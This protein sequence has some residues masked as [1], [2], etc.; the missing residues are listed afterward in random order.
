MGVLTRGGDVDYKRDLKDKW[1]TDRRQE[2]EHSESSLQQAKDKAAGETKTQAPRVLELAAS[3]TVTSHQVCDIVM[4]SLSNNR[5][6]SVS[7]W[8][9]VAFI[10]KNC[11][12]TRTMDPRCRVLHERV[13]PTLHWKHW[14]KPVSLINTHTEEFS[15]QCSLSNYNH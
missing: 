11:P 3:W 13:P 4:T 9:N 5:M 2:E 8:M 15:C 1:N 12:P 7:V 14:G 6:D 10:W